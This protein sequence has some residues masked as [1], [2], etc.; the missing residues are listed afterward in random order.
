[1]DSKCIVE[2]CQKPKWSK[3]LCSMHWKRKS[4]HGDTSIVLKPYRP[5]PNQGK[6]WTTPQGYRVLA[7]DGKKIFEHRYVMQQHL[8]R[9]LLPEENVHHIN[10]V[11]DDNRLENLELWVTKQP[12][13]QRVE[14]AVEHALRVLK[15][16]APHHLT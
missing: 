3:G 6:G 13:G 10:G 1:M 7:I 16:Y 8:G 2:D 4:K 15:L 12:R 9:D 5:P 11:R 14:D